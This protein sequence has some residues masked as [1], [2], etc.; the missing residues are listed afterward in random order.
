[1]TRLHYALIAGAEW[2]L[3][4]VVLAFAFWRGDRLTR[5]FAAIMFLGQLAATLP[6]RLFDLPRWWYGLVDAA[7]LALMIA[8]T[9]R[10]PRPWAV[11]A[12]GFQLA[13]VATAGAYALDRDIGP[14]ALATAVNMWWLLTIAALAWGTVEAVR[15][16]PAKAASTHPEPERADA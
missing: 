2:S 4:A 11:W 15:R 5:R 13:A 6:F 10:E 7:C 1:M 16:A 9:V 3:W 14:L 12:C 8:A